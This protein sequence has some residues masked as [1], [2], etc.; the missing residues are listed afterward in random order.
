[1]IFLLTVGSGLFVKMKAGVLF[2]GE[3]LELYNQF[4]TYQ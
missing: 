4:S 1:M 2:V 3:L